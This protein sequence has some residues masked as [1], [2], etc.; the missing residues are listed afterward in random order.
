MYTTNYSSRA[1]SSLLALL[2]W[3]SR[4][5]LTDGWERR[6]GGRNGFED[7][8][9][10]SGK[11]GDVDAAAAAAAAALA[12][13]AAANGWKSVLARATEAAGSNPGGKKW[14]SGNGAGAAGDAVG[15][16]VELLE[17]NLWW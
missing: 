14:W 3:S 4:S 6:W 12:A 1:S 13:A 8:F 2:G 10:A 15:G 9:A 11:A 5:R 16:P 7:I 17:E